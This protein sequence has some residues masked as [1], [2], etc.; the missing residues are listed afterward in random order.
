MADLLVFGPPAVL[1]LG[2]SKHESY[3]LRTIPFI[4]HR[5]ENWFLRRQTIFCPTHQKPLKLEVLTIQNFIDFIHINHLSN[6]FIILW[7]TKV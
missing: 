2:V 5:S 4:D 1:Y 6:F 3:A 7:A